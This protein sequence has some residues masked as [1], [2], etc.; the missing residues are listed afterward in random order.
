MKLPFDGS[1]FTAIKIQHAIILAKN[2]NTNVIQ[3]DKK[4]EELSQITYNAYG[5]LY[6]A[7][8]VR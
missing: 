6:Y 2:N 7:K 4:L 3:C 1:F 5:E 8:S